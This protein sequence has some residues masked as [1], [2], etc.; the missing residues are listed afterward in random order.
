MR[1][2]FSTAIASGV[3][4][5]ALGYAAAS[6][7]VLK[8]IT[9]AKGPTIDRHPRGQQLLSSDATV[10]DSQSQLEGTAATVC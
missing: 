6:R 4:G 1:N 3:V 7:G 2:L 8:T 5:L 9:A 10:S